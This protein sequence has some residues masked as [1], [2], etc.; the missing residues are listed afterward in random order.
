MT[1]KT[2]NSDNE[3]AASHSSAGNKQ[4]TK[5]KTTFG[6]IDSKPSKLQQVQKHHRIL[7]LTR[8]LN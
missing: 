1:L 8:Y 6:Y 3:L 7:V 4:Q 5:T 2:V